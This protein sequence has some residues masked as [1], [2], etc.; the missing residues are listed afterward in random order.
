MEHRI[1]RHCPSVWRSRVQVVIIRLGRGTLELH[2]MLMSKMVLKV[3][4]VDV[5]HNV[6]Y[7]LFALVDTL[8]AL[9]FLTVV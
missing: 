1:V 5:S 7:K 9:S 4:S 3:H 2:L 8:G 6:L